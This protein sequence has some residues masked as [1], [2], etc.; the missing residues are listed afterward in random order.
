MN[1]KELNDISNCEIR[2]F[3][4]YKRSL[5]YSY[6]GSILYQLKDIDHMILEFQRS[7]QFSIDSILS[8]ECV[9]YIV[10]KKE[11][12]QK[13]AYAC[14]LRQF[15]LYLIKIGK[16]AYVIPKK[17]LP[18][19]KRQ[20]NPYIFDNEEIYNVIKAVDN[21]CQNTTNLNPAIKKT[22]PFIIRLL[23]SCGLR[24]SEALNLRR[25]NVNLIEKYIFI[26]D[27]KNNKCRYI[28]L[29]ESMYKCLKKYENET[30]FVS[31]L[32]FQIDSSKLLTKEVVYYHYKKIIKNIGYNENLTNKK[33]SLHTLRHTAAV[34]MIEKMMN[35]DINVNQDIYL[36][37]YFLGHETIIETEV[38]IHLP[39]YKFNDLSHISTINELFPEVKDNEV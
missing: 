7:H 12:N 13:Y 36:L 37:S 8:K 16:K 6:H 28:P 39:Y 17:S 27:G 34:H 19:M 21:Y 30:L 31:N 5:G 33:M 1:K 11:T 2:Q 3:I 9:E 10:S 14:L 26:E 4:F 32:Y 29:S 25:E 35:N 38:Y 22:M 18:A 24:I 15:G 20:F 23:Y